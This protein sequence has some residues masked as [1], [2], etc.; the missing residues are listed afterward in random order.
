MMP[1]RTDAE[2]GRLVRKVIRGERLKPRRLHGPTMGEMLGS[3][4]PHCRCYEE[5][6]ADFMDNNRFAVVA[7]LEA[8]QPSRNRKPCP[9]HK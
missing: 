2:I 5:S 3:P 8:L 1:R 4:G 9:K 7:L 6:D